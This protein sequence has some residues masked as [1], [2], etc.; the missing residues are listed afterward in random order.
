MLSRGSMSLR[1]GSTLFLA[2]KVRKKEGKTKETI[3][4]LDSIYIQRLFLNSWQNKK[5]GTGKLKNPVPT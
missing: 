5:I 4:F 2:T 1:D 3:L